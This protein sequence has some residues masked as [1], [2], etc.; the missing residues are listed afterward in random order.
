MELSSL[1]RGVAGFP[2]G[3]AYKVG[4]AS[5]YARIPRAFFRQTL[6]LG[7]ETKKVDGDN[8]LAA[9]VCKLCD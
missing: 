5:P 7:G 3:E 6:D 1:T 4:S 2:S 8:A 9:A